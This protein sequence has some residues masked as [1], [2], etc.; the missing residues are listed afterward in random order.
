[1]RCCRKTRAITLIELLVVISIIGL[2]VGLLLPAVQSAREVARRISCQ[3]NL[4]QIGLAAQ[5]HVDLHK[6]L[7][8]DGWGYR[9]VGD[10]EFGYGKNQPGGWVF[11]LLS[12]VEQ[13]NVRT[14]AAGQPIAQ[15]ADYLK[16]MVQQPISTF[17]CPS[18]RVADL[19]PFA[20]NATPFNVAP[21]DLSSIPVAKTDYAVNGGS[22]KIDT[23][24]G[25]SSRLPTD[26]EAYNWPDLNLFNGVSAVRSQFKLA[27]VSD[28]LSNT[29]LVGEKYISIS[30]PTGFFGDDQTMYVGDDA[31]IRRWGTLPPL[32]DQSRIE[33]RDAFG[34][35]HAGG[36]SFVLCD[37]SVQLVSF[38]V[39]EVLHERKCNRRDGQVLT[40]P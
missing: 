22:V 35:R 9:W 19:Y 32:Q 28:G 15:R 13:D 18:R 1:M 36:C 17:N 39:D 11:N 20:T 21:N 37:G 23:G 31:D 40:E 34:S 16:K 24:P 7:P 27:D 29:Y 38:F 5:L 12:F 3:N 33:T 6:H 8:T 10:P 2:L 30:D 26:L 14:I 25:P 4:K